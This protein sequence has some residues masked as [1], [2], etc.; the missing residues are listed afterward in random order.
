MKNNLTHGMT[1]LQS[2][3]DAVRQ[4]G[5]SDFEPNPL[6]CWYQARWNAVLSDVKGNVLGVLIDHADVLRFR[7]LV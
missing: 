7:A 6:H 2:L 1:N 4:H 3:L 5:R